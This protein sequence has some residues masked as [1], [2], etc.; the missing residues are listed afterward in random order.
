MKL[1]HLTS[2]VAVGGAT[3]ALA[4]A[5]LVG[6]TGTSASAAPVSTI[7]TC[8]LP[9]FGNQPFTVTVDAAIP[10]TGVA[11]LPVPAG[12]LSFK[13]TLTA[14]PAVASALNGVA[15]GAKSDDF[16]TAFG[17]TTAKAPVS[18]PT[19]VTPDNPDGSRTFTGTG[20][21]GAFVL[22]QAGTYSV[23][24][25]K[26]FTLTPTQNGAALP[27]T[28]SCTSASPAQIGTITL[29]KQTSTTKVKG[30][31][32]VKKGGVESLKVKVA[33]QYSKTG[34]P[35]PTGKVVVKD[36]SQTLGKG[37]L[38]NGKVTIKVKGLT[39]GSHTVVV[40]Y[41][42]DSFTSKSKSKSLNVTVTK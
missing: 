30:A 7:Y 23:A 2:R 12:L 1:A 37:K 27:F 39:V 35:V 21:N 15:N 13:S 25:P 4:A 31:K 22:P 41:A 5:A 28:G 34:G 17:A 3:A 40:K 26:A 38:K 11:G 20:A 36:G 10:T 19:Q 32:T 18:W 6:V 24:M 42:G 16:S 29:S 8:A 9:S 33:N 14:P